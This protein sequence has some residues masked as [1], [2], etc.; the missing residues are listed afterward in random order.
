M[1][2]HKTMYEESFI[3]IYTEIKQKLAKE[4]G[5]F[6]RLATLILITFRHHFRKI[7]SRQKNP[8]VIGSIVVAFKFQY[9]SVEILVLLL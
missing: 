9:S 8:F 4:V 6:T 1:P 2:L 3:S 5:R 7:V